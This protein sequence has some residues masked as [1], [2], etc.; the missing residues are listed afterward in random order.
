MAETI[1]IGRVLHNSFIRDKSDFVGFSPLFADPF[2][3]NFLI[4]VDGGAALPS[5]HVLN[6]DLKVV[7]K[8]MHEN[9]KAYR[10]DLR[11]ISVFLK[12]CNG[13]LSIPE[14]DFGIKFVRQAIA[15]Q[16][17]PEFMNSINVLLNNLR[18]N[19][20][21]LAASGLNTE[22]LKELER[23]SLAIA[24]DDVLKRNMISNRGQ[25]SWN[26]AAEMNNLNELMRLVME[27]GKALYK[28][29]N[30]ARA[31]DYTLT[32]LKRKH[33]IALQ[34]VPPPVLN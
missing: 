15:S 10:T 23:R 24:A 13:T 17:V 5:I 22:L 26:N 25:V 8:R 34:P 4:A 29:N 11:K 30:P 14:E 1:Q 20:K 6:A 3:D 31:R 2:A 9:M 33:R 7:V 21:P 16:K 32:D 27:G 18:V 19:I 28:S 12:L